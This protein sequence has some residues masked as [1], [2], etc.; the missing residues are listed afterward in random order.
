MLLKSGELMADGPLISLTVC[1]RNA[2]HWVDDCLRSLVKQTY[3]PLEIIAVDDGS[4]DDGF[5]KLQ[6]WEGEHDGIV[7]TVLKQSPLGLSAGRN[8]AFEHSKGEWV[9][10]TDIDCRPDPYWIS[11]M[12][13]VSEGLDDEEV[14]AVTG[15][16]I[17][18]EGETATSGLRESSIARK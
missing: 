7:V 5:A 6:S 12:F 4:T 15:R 2:E 10:I 1:M 18:D 17:F 14:L 3:R 8:L 13:Q 11:E 16:T 9:A